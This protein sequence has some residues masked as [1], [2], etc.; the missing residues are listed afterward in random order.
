MLIFY[1]QDTAIEGLLGELHIEDRRLTHGQEQIDEWLE[2]LQ[3]GEKCFLFLDFDSDEESAQKLNHLFA[4]DERLIRIIITH[5]SKL[6]ELKESSVSAHGYLCRPLDALAIS[7]VLHD[8]QLAEFTARH[9]LFEEG[10]ELPPMPKD[11]KNYTWVH[12]VAHLTGMHSVQGKMESYQSSLNDKI[13]RKFDEVFGGQQLPSQEN[14]DFELPPEEKSKGEAQLNLEG[15]SEEES[16]SSLEQTCAEGDNKN[17]LEDI[18]FEMQGDGEE[19]EKSEKEEREEVELNLEGACEDVDNKKC[20]KKESEEEEAKIHLKTDE[21]KGG[22]KDR[23]DLDLNFEQALEEEGPDEDLEK[24]EENMKD[25]NALKLDHELDDSEDAGKSELSHSNEQSKEEK[26]GEAL[27]EIEEEQESASGKSGTA[28]PGESTQVALKFFSQQKGSDGQ[29]GGEDEGGE[30]EEEV[31]LGEESQVHL[32]PAAFKPHLTHSEVILKSIQRQEDKTRT[33]TETTR[34]AIR[35][36]GMTKTGAQLKHEEQ[37]VLGEETGLTSVG[38]ISQIQ[39]L[40]S[41]AL[42]NDKS[43]I[44]IKAPELKKKDTNKVNLED[45][46]LTSLLDLGIQAEELHQKRE[47]TEQEATGLINITPEGERTPPS[48]NEGEMLRLQATIR[49]LREEREQLLFKAKETVVEIKTL[50]QE[51]LALRAELDEIKIEISIAKKRHGDEADEMKYRVR[52]SDEKCMLLGEK[53]R[54]LKKE[55]DRLEQKVRVDFGQI[56]RREKDLESRLELAQ[57]DSDTQVKLRDQKIL[58]LKRK[59]DQLE[60]NM[61][62]IAI[63]EQKT[64]D[65]KLKLE[66]NLTKI[67]KTLRGSIEFL[68]DDLGLGPEIKDHLNRLK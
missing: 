17:N 20:L 30:S 64:R 7:G 26:K 31:E 51:N 55:F 44:Q 4:Q 67:A 3:E 21:K 45:T 68:E 52:L 48:Y 59:I 58:E 29:E 23:D 38:E 54:K 14:L 24:E 57:M 33:K 6:K 11:S 66:E 2:E 46:G 65:E 61:E 13:Q 53:N 47:Q 39:E 56:Q 34:T 62:N 42:D 9:A 19:G 35:K 8:F 60:F 43:Q 12:R 16:K 27:L 28:E 22:E 50:E 49:Q 15:T 36:T 18:E 25:G 10:M 5:K 63:K 41:G 40:D 37:L 32:N 1:T